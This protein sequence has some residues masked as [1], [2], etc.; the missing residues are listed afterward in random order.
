MSKMQTCHLLDLQY[1]WSTYKCEELTP[2]TKF[3][4]QR[5]MRRAAESGVYHPAVPN[6]ARLIEAGIFALVRRDASFHPLNSRAVLLTGDQ[7]PQR[8]DSARNAFWTTL[9]PTSSV[10]FL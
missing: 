3:Q 10:R 7:K 9:S 1:N 6:A 5:R 8:R 2:I 4:R